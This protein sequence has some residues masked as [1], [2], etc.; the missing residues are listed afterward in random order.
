MSW[1]PYIGLDFST[2]NVYKNTN[3]TGYELLTSLAASNTTYNDTAANVMD[4]AYEY[5]IAIE[6]PDCNTVPLMSEFIK[7]NLEYINPNLGISDLSYLEESISLFPNPTSS[8][9]Q[10]N[11]S[12]DIDIIRR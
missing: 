8:Q 2:Y 10:I 3:G 4:N 6:A 11:T 9:V 1:T 12:N 5:Y 7:S